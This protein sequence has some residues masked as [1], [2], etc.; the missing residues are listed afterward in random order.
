MKSTT[1][2]PFARLGIIGFK[3]L[4][5]C[6][7]AASSA[8]NYNPMPWC[9]NGTQTPPPDRDKGWQCYKYLI[10]TAG[11]GWFCAGSDDGAVPARW[12]Q[13][14]S[15][16][17]DGGHSAAEPT[18]AKL[19]RMTS[20]IGVSRS[21]AALPNQAVAFIKAQ[22][23]RFEPM[24]ECGSITILDPENKSSDCVLCRSELA[25]GNE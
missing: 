6:F 13:R 20:R 17:P 16:L 15:W 3:A 7:Q 8:A 23:I 5:D 1:L 4:A 24:D 11:C 14:R 18:L 10:V 21:Q 19:T 22:E 9:S 2:I 25:G 12:H